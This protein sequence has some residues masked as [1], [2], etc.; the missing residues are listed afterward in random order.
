MCRHVGYL[1]PALPLADIVLRGP[2][3]LLHQSW[4]PEDMRG[5]TINADGFGVAWHDPG[6]AA[7][8]R[9]YRR[10]TP[11]WSD[12]S[13]PDLAESISSTTIVAAVRSATAGMPV[14][15][16]ACAPFIEGPWMFSH[17][18]VVAD[19]PTSVAP[20]S[21]SLSATELMA[22]EAPTDS[23]FLWALVRHLL[24]TG[25]SGAEALQS[26]AV[27]VLALAPS[28]R[29]NLLLSD[30]QEMS[31]SVA[32]HSL[33]VREAGDSITLSSEPL[34]PADPSWKPIAEGHLVE[35]SADHLS[36]RPLLQGQP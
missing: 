3:S 31:A 8:A 35:A 20:L 21:D 10:E 15:V 28:S 16:T 4:A 24:H 5:A 33:W 26:V 18:G 12:E 2:H 29:L 34:D 25:H 9:R 32:G 11:I 23:A 22:I 30:G 17:N 7:P 6:R 36:I 13:L 1:G 19:W 14:V 27:D